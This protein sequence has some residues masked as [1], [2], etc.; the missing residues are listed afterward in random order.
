MDNAEPKND[1]HF[2]LSYYKLCVRFES[3]QVILFFK[4][5]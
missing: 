4:L 3:A 2:L 1:N 5:I